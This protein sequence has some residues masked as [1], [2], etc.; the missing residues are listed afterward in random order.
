M[1]FIADIGSNH[2]QSLSRTELLI[3]TAKSCGCNAVKFQLFDRRL[4]RDEMMK[5]KLEQTMLPMHFLPEI[6]GMCLDNNIE[7]HCTP[8]HKDLV[9]HLVQYVDAF[10]VGSYEL[11]YLDLI[12][13]CSKTGKPLGISIGAGTREELMKAVECVEDTDLLTL[14]HCMP[15]YPTPPDQAGLKKI[16]DA[17]YPGVLSVGYSDHTRNMGVVARASI[18]VDVIEFHL[19]LEGEGLE[20]HHGHCWMPNEAREMINLVSDMKNSMSTDYDK[21]TEK[22][23]NIRLSRTDPSDGARPILI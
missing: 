8:F 1:K 19:D 16:F 17:G 10:K 11:L 14:Y 21:Q 18:Y 12:K 7:F 13:E 9:G 4:Y 20:S 15:F 6:K 3:K 22:W 2:N 5:E 23:M